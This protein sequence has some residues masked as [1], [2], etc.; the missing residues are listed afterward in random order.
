MS[1]QLLG[2]V[3]GDL[4]DLATDF[5]SGLFILPEIRSGFFQLSERL[6]RLDLPRVARTLDVIF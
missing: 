6:L 4:A 2:G 3:D 5:S 1:L